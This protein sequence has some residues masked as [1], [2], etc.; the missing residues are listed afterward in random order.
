M[1]FVRI[2]EDL[3]CVSVFTVYLCISYHFL[4]LSKAY[5]VSSFGFNL[6]F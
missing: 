5:L 6:V 3:N 2:R 4:V 1:F